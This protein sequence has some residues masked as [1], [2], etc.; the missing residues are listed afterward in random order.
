MKSVALRYLDI[1]MEQLHVLFQR[2]E[3]DIQKTADMIANSLMNGHRIFVANTSHALATEIHKRAGGLVGVIPLNVLNYDDPMESDDRIPHLKKAINSGNW[4]PGKGD[5]V[6]IA[7][8]AGTNIDTVG[9]AKICREQEATVIGITSLI[10]EKSK[11]VIVQ[12]PQ[13]QTLADIAHL[14][15]DLGGVIGDAVISLDHLPNPIA[16]TSGVLTITVVWAILAQAADIMLKAGYIPLVYRAVQ[17]PGGNEL[18][19]KLSAQFVKN[20]LGYQQ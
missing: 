7:S 11:N 15:I 4:K 17:L 2:S 1:I 9:A 19:T 18:F 5:I 10:F 13:K 12:D 16:P 3:T 8:N 14:V 6:I 20:G